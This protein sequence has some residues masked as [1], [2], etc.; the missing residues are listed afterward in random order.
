MAEDKLSPAAAAVAAQVQAAAQGSSA[1]DL[2]VADMVAAHERITV[3]LRRLEREQALESE[4]MAFKMAVAELQ[5]RLAWASRGLS[6]AIGVGQQL[7][8]QASGEATGA[9]A[10]PRQ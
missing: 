1:L 6:E 9:S 3:A 5:G 7:A 8:Q 10:Q 2:A 4:D